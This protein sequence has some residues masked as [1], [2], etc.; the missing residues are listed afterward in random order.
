MLIALET[1]HSVFYKIFDM[2]SPYFYTG[3]KFKTA[4]ITL[5]ET[6]H[7]LSFVV[8]KQFW[9]SL[10]EKQ[11][12]FI[13]AHEACH[14]ICNHGPRAFVSK[15]PKL[16]NIAAD[17]SIN[18]YLATQFEFIRSEIDP[19]NL[20]CWVDTV[21]KHVP[22]FEQIPTDETLEYY[23]E[24]LLVH[25]TAADADKSGNTPSPQLV[26]SHEF[27]D[28]TDVV[29]DLNKSL[30][31][32][33]KQKLK[34]L[35]ARG[36]SAGNETLILQN[37]E[38]IKPKK[39]WESIITNWAIPIF[40]EDFLEIES[41]GLTSRRLSTFDLGKIK[42][43]FDREVYDEIPIKNRTNVWFFQDTSSSCKNF[44][45]RFFSAAKSLPS[46]RFNV[47]MFCFDTKIYETSLDSGK[48]YGFGGTSFSCIE[49]GIQ[50]LIRKEKIHYPDNIFVITDGEG[51]KVIPQYPKKWTW[52]LSQNRK[53]CIPKESKIFMLS[54]FE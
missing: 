24:L 38:P 34:D 41:W 20:Y 7:Y 14:V 17:L 40:E 19:A 6:G 45:E 15:D 54:E 31:T 5:D 36:N 13:F 10:N 12:P 26:D 32:K 46:A 21:F 11:K 39:K 22:D 42:L 52:L 53:S 50:L 48:L 44:A 25:G 33:E 49:N 30:D 51:D 2:G 27:Q 35:L 16:A 23:Y 43:P 3:D 9:N 1:I 8:N 37:V 18:H 28:F 4:A 29:K 47:R